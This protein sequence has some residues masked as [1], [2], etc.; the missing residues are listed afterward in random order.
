MATT[1]PQE[2]SLTD[3]ALDR[4]SPQ[5]PAPPRPAPPAVNKS[6]WE[7]SVDKH[8]LNTLTVRQV[9]LIVFN[10]TQPFTDSDNANDT[11][12]GAREK[13][14]HTLINAD[15][16]FGKER[17]RTAHPI[18]PTANQLKNPRVKRAYESS[19]AAARDAYLSAHDPTGRAT[20][21]QFLTNASRSNI[22]FKGGTPE[23]LAIKTQSGP[24]NNSYTGGDVPSRHVYVDPYGK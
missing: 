18:E 9:G 10:E 22:R 12:G 4:I 21:F 20:N 6:A 14:A 17:P 2:R 24:F 19:L 5:P 8:K 11:I 1:K 16:K 15:S 7:E 13:V 3:R 23:G